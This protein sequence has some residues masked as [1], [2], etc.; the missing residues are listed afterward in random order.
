MSDQSKT[1]A[2]LPLAG[3]TAAAARRIVAGREA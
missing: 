2:P 1:P 3:S